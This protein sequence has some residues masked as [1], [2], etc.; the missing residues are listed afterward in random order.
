MT[1]EGCSDEVL[2]SRQAP[3]PATISQWATMGS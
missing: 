2:Y 1:I 3:N